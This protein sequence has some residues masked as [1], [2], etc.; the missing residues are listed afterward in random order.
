MK[1]L[2][3][4][5]LVFFAIPISLVAQQPENV[6][7]TLLTKRT[8]TWCG[9]CGSWGWQMFEH[10]LDENEGKAILL[11]AHHS[12]DL[13]SNV[14]ED[15]TDNFTSFSQPRFFLNHTDQNTTSGNWASKADDIKSQVDEAF[16]NQTP[17]AN[18]GFTALEEPI[19]G[20]ITIE[21]N[22]EFF[23]PANGD[24]YLGV[25]VVESN[26]IN[27]QA[28]QGNN[29][30]HAKVLRSSFTSNS[31]GVPIVNGDVTAGETFHLGTEKFEQ[32]NLQDSPDIEYVAIIWK[33]VG[34]NYQVVNVHLE[35]ETE[36]TVSNTSELDASIADFTISP[37]PSTTN[38]Q[39]ELNLNDNYNNLELEIWDV[40][41]KA[42]W[43]VETGNFSKGS[44]HFEISK[45]DLGTAGQ[46]YVKLSIENK[47]KTKSLMIFN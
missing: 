47:I 24:Y 34:N 11:A 28:S 27:F 3:I 41:G 46:F 23:Q 20:I 44:H 7:R 31:F 18:V 29:A 12:G 13:H 40:S 10:L 19:A 36:L 38:V 15:I 17:I 45:S 22:V 25:Y 30:N 42:V 26:I 1:R 21:A 8:A 6:Q 16:N 32:I 5:V 33:K 35:T 39:I 43:Q 37:N 4:L 2:T 9:P 14:A